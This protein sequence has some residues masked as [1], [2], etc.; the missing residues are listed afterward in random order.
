MSFSTLQYDWTYFDGSFSFFR[1]VYFTESWEKRIAF[2]FKKGSNFHNVRSCLLISN[3]KT[4][5]CILYKQ[6]ATKGK[7]VWG[8]ELQPSEFLE[9]HKKVENQKSSYFGLLKGTPNMFS[10]LRPCLQDPARPIQCLLHYCS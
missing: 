4:E 10:R 7:I 6:T 8:N 2:E 5:C 9:T 3:L 1:Q